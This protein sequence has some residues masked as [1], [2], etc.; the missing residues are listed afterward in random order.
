MMQLEYNGRR[1]PVAAGETVVGSDPG[2]A[3][4]IDGEGVLPRHL[5]LLGAGEAAVAVRRAVDEAEVLVNG[6]RLGADPTPVLHGDKIQLGSVELFVV[7]SRIAGSTQ[8][9][10]AEALRA[11]VPTPRTSGPRPAVGATGGRLVCLTDGREYQVGPEGLVFGRDAVCDVVVTGNEVSRRHAQIEPGA[12]GYVLSDLSANGS[13]VNGERLEGPRVLARADIIRIGSDEFRFYAQPVAS[14]STAAELSGSPTAVPGPYVSG[15]LPA[16]APPGAAQRLFDTM[17]GMPRSSLPDTPIA[18]AQAALASVLVRS[19]ALKGKR[20]PIRSAVVNIGRAEYNDLVLPEPSVSTTHAKLQRRDGVW[21]LVDLGSTNGTTVEGEAVEAEMALS[22][23]VTIK[24]GEVAVLFE[25]LDEAVEP[26][27]AGAQT[28]PRL[29][30]LE[31]EA[32]ARPAA[33]RPSGS[34]KRPEPPKNKT[35]P[36]WLIITLVGAVLAA[37]AITLL[38]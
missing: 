8:M 38:T 25:P 2:C 27:L 23:G 35:A 18:P 29:A 28:Q 31:I 16:T 9:M 10:D 30:P 36:A 4:A 1:H 13:L 24:F 12:E 5:V 26:A 14:A 19:G 3:L 37:I 21:I 34:R 11:V 15:E 17:H 7:E 22:P 33:R 20:L 6:V 32:P